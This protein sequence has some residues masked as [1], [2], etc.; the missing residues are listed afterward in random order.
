VWGALSAGNALAA[1]AAIMMTAVT[2]ISLIYR[3]SPRTPFRL[4]WD[5]AALIGMYLAVMAALY[6]IG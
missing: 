4:T 2:I 3:A 1:V 5:G 6:V